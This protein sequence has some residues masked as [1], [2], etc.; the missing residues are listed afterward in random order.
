MKKIVSILICLLLALCLAA[1]CFAASYR[2]EIYRLNDFAGVLNA[3]ELDSIDDEIC[4]FIDAYGVDL[5]ICIRTDLGDTDPYDFLDR[6]YE[7]NGYGA[8]DSKDAVAMLI[9]SD[10]GELYIVSYGDRG[11]A[12]I[13]AM[14]ENSD[15]DDAAA[16][17]NSS[18]SS[19]EYGSALRKYVEAAGSAAKD[20]FG[21]SYSGS[22]GH[23]GSSGS[24]AQSGSSGSSS[25]PGSKASSS[26]T[27]PSWFP[28]DD[29]SF[30]EFHDYDAPRLVDNAD[31]FTAAEE[32]QILEHIEKLRDEQGADLVIFTDTSTHGLSARDYAIAFHRYNGYGFGDDYSGSIL[33]IC[34]DPSDRQ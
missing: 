7:D 10:A 12:L 14:S 13:E 31:M 32:A 3:G 5:P 6:F 16:A 19:G 28:A 22:S 27:L 26:S 21:T 25:Q 1:P 2:E 33:F 30:V 24:S 15:M 4:D 29:S 8:G 18:F 34:M 9:L 20:A 17:L 23:S 11:E